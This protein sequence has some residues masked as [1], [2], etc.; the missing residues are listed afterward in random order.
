MDGPQGTYRLPMT[1][2]RDEPQ[3]GWLALAIT[4]VVGG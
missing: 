2:D 1:G 4:E 3:D